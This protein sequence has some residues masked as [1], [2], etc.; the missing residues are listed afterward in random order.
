MKRR[1]NTRRGTHN[2]A[3]PSLSVASTSS[4]SSSKPAPSCR[5]QPTGGSRRVTTAVSS[6]N[7]ATTTTASS[8][9]SGSA[10]SADDESVRVARWFSRLSARDRVDALTTADPMACQAVVRMRDIETKA[11]HQPLVLPPPSSLFAPPPKPPSSSSA[12]PNATAARGAAPAIACLSLAEFRQNV[13][14]GKVVPVENCGRS[15]FHSRCV[16]RQWY[17]PVF[18]FGV[19]FDSN[20]V[21]FCTTFCPSMR[22]HPLS[23]SSSAVDDEQLLSGV[24]LGK[25]GP[26][27]NITVRQSIVE[28]PEHFITMMRH[29][30]RGGFLSNPCRM[31]LN[32][33]RQWVCQDPGWWTAGQYH[34]LPQF[35][36]FL[37]EKSLWSYYWFHSGEVHI[38]SAAKRSPIPNPTV[39]PPLPSSEIYQ[40]WQNI[41]DR[42]RSCTIAKIAPFLQHL[43]ASVPQKY[44]EYHDLLELLQDLP[45]FSH[46]LLHSDERVFIDNLFF[47]PL[48]RAGSPSDKL[49]LQIGNIIQQSKCEH[50]GA[51]K[52]L[53]PAEMQ[54]DDVVEALKLQ[55]RSLEKSVADLT[56]QN[57]ELQ[58]RT[59]QLEN[60]CNQSVDNL[61]KSLKEEVD[62]STSFQNTINTMVSL[63]SATASHFRVEKLLGTG[64]NGAA[65]HVKYFTAFDNNSSSEA[66]SGALATSS[67]TAKE[68]TATTKRGRDLVMKVLFNF[69]NISQQTM[70]RQKYMAECATLALVPSHPNVIHPLGAIV[71]PCLP[72]EF[73]EKI[74]PSQLYFREMCRLKSLAILMPHAGITLS[75]F[76]SSLLQPTYPSKTNEKMVKAVHSLF[77]QG[78]KAIQHIESHSIAHRDIKQDNILVDPESGKL[79]LIDFGEAQQCCPPNMEM[80]ITATTQPWGNTGTMPPELSMFLKRM[81]M[82]GATRGSF[83][84]SKCDSFALALT[85]WDALL[86]QSHRFF[87]S[88]MNQDMSTFLTQSLLS[89]FPVPLFS[90]VAQ[91]LPSVDGTSQ[92]PHVLESV[93]IDMMITDKEARLCAADA[94]HRLTS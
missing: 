58:N 19:T 92:N 51:T 88:Q 83:S 21:D 15:A 11:L 4:S 53:H 91:P 16:V 10:A 72:D 31:Q 41:S 50:R 40:F 48:Y 8:S 82:T 1:N 78:C 7:C 37:L 65:F 73:V 44:L 38:D 59:A 66:M 87:G 28:S 84:F 39:N 46:F 77:V 76:L 49:I 52:S 32:S 60:L 47:S 26:M 36:A 81:R 23:W 25:H 74:P 45:S 68:T 61:N 43:V 90:F 93:M 75:V 79:T 64:S 13:L 27:E 57:R 70:L 67:K 86:P 29:I 2:Q 56:F 12:S 35:L 63:I 30:S 5:P 17:N 69:E 34:T 55:V 22:S 18:F 54:Q 62:R 80:T 71:T 94:I 33:D 85:F 9:S 24:C 3:A 6:S 42:Q 89:H 20:G 14:Q